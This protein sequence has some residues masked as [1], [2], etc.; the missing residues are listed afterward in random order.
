MAPAVVVALLALAGL[1]ATLLPRLGADPS[2]DVPAARSLSPKP[3]HV[4]LPK[5]RTIVRDG[6]VYTVGLVA[7]MGAERV[8]TAADE[9]KVFTDEEYDAKQPYCNAIQPSARVT[10]EDADSVTIAISDYARRP[11]PHRVGCYYY[12]TEA[13][14][15][16]KHYTTIAVHLAGPLGN[17]RLIDARTHEP[18]GLIP[19]PERP[20]PGYLPSG[21]VK[22]ENESF[23][24]S[25]DLIA[26]GEYR[27][28]GDSIEIRFRSR[29]A[30]TLD[31]NIIGHATV[32]GAPATITNES[33][34]RCVSWSDPPGIVREVCSLS[35]AGFLPSSTLLKIADSLRY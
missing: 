25:E 18:I 28:G 10:H 5:P 22:S 2:R 21:Y 27:R 19:M 24:Q 29:T 14:T 26:I 16:P 15:L 17:R 35:N 4:A 3:M 13:P 34:E 7:P 9:V 1:A 6:T 12:E 11:L 20:D 33:Y 23:A 30:W 32:H 8:A 31:G